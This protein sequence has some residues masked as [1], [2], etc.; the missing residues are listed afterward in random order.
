MYRCRD[1]HLTGPR[2]SLTH[3]TLTKTKTHDLATCTYICRTFAPLHE[4]RLLT[5]CGFAPGFTTTT[6]TTTTLSNSTANKQ[7]ARDHCAY[8]TRPRHSTRKSAG[9]FGSRLMCATQSRRFFLFARARLC[10][11]ASKPWW[12]SLSHSLY[13]SHL[14]DKLSQQYYH[15]SSIK[16][17]QSFFSTHRP[18]ST[19]SSSN[20]EVSSFI[21]T[22]T[23]H[24]GKSHANDEKQCLPTGRIQKGK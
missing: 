5:T 20:T 8:N 10:G 17:T 2:S 18:L 12:H 15:S 23:H 21:M 3:T 13:G 7:E 14:Y 19:Y 4:A 24:W 22:C 9:G 1:G 6:T 11:T 16:P